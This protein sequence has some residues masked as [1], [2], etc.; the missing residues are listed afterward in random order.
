[1]AQQIL[2]RHRPLRVVEMKDGPPVGAG[3]L[4]TDLH[5][6]DLGQVLRYGVADLELAL[7]D[8]LHERHAHDRLG[9]GVDA[10]D[11]FSLH[12]GVDALVAITERRSPGNL[13]VACHQHDGTRHQAGLDM[14]LR[15]ILDALELHRGQ[16]DILGL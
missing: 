7:L 11:R 9:H 8:H 10:E 4:D 3:L 14:L 5:L 2:H 16:A 15:H 13:A 6:A 12:L 1:M